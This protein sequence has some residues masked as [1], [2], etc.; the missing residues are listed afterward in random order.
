MLQH[1]SAC[2]RLKITFRTREPVQLPQRQALINSATAHFPD[3]RVLERRKP[4]LAARQPQMPNLGRDLL[5]TEM[6]K[7]A[8]QLRIGGPRR[9]QTRKLPDLGLHP[10]MA[11]P[12]NAQSC[13]TFLKSR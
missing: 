8:H 3:R 6:W 9:D 13:S 2:A 11:R 7:G 12:D 1:K 5:K 4:P 10:N